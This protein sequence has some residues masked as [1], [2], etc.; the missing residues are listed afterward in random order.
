VTALAGAPLD[1]THLQKGCQRYENPNQV[2]I[3][4]AKLWQCQ[5]TS[6]PIR[7]LN[8]ADGRIQAVIAVN[9]VINPI[10][11]ATSLGLISTP[12]LM[13]TGT[14][15]IFA[16]PLSEQLLPYT[17]LKTADRILALVNGGT[18]LSF[19]AD[20]GKLPSFLVGPNQREA[21]TELK[22]LSLLF[23]NRYLNAI[24]TPANLMPPQA[25][26]VVGTAP[27]QMMVFRQLSKQRLRMAAPITCDQTAQD[28]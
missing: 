12:Y 6:Q 20:T 2:E 27:L 11:R 26:L 18:H 13:I 5:D 15:D 28:C 22:A 21:F 14:D 9:P 16:P 3:N 10:F 7:Q 23:F 24:E 17:S 1:W 4:L 8:Q 19:L 25:P